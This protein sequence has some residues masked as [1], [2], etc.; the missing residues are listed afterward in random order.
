VSISTC[1]CWT[2]SNSLRQL[3][4]SQAASMPLPL[5]PPPG[6]DEWLGHWML[7]IADRYGLS[8]DRFLHRLNVHPPDPPR[9]FAWLHPVRW[10]CS[11]WQDFSCQAR[12][13]IASLQDMQAVVVALGRGSE[14]G[15]CP[16]CV[17]DAVE[18]GCYPPFW[19]RS[20]MDATSTWCDEHE[21][22]LAV[23][24]HIA[25][26]AYRTCAAVRDALSKLAQTHR[27][28]AAAWL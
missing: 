6:A 22:P 14:Y 1:L 17:S 4:Q 21:T 26:L 8:P 15:F 11:Q 13:G 28:G 2:K 25:Q 16:R 5:V 20:W 9:I 12:I 7:R 24:P 10:S 18:G 23:C 27:E 19:R 3:E